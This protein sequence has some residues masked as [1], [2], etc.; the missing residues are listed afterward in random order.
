M[1]EPVP[2]RA[3]LKPD[4]PVW[5]RYVWL[6]YLGFYLP[7]LPSPAERPWLL[8]AELA[9]L[10][11]FLGLYFRFYGRE[12]PSAWFAVAGMAALGL[13]LTPVNFGA[14]A[15]FVYAMTFSAFIGTTRQGLL[16]QA[17][18]VALL[19][20]SV[21]AWNLHPSFV[22]GILGI[23]LGTGLGCI[24]QAAN[25]RQQAALRRSQEEVRQL[26][27]VAERERIGR[28]LHDLLGHTLS[29]IA[30]KAELAERLSG[31]EPQRAADEIGDVARI[32]REALAEVRQAVAGYRSL[33]L[34]GELMRSEEALKS[35]GV[36]LDAEI[37]PA[38][39]PA[40]QEAVLSLAL[41]EAVTNVIRHAQARRCRV[42][43][44][45]QPDAVVL[46]VHDDGRGGHHY[47]GGHG[48]A[49]MRD[50]VGSLG[51]DVSV[52]ADNGTRVELRL[53]LVERAA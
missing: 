40:E 35:A 5:L 14:W 24:G 10:L 9:A 11:A 48:L 20:Q 8:A 12:G 43:L 51:G 21:L 49:G 36:T 1:G 33:G 39:L 7:G 6:I 13:A 44:Q 41:R 53:P 30:L 3:S 19:L 15:F 52:V 26:A 34:R 4:E 45:Q 25:R 22:L 37:A 38:A 17:L 32:S 23:S 2:P 29:V 31:V 46:T 18:I 16:A 47:G 42:R 50:R 28:D 27:T